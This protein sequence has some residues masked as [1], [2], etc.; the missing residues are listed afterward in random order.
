MA[1]SLGFEGRLELGRDPGTLRL[2]GLRVLA[3]ALLLDP[4]EFEDLPLERGSH[5]IGGLK[6]LGGLSDQL[7]EPFSI[8]VV[9]LPRLVQ[10]PA[11]L[12]DLRA[13]RLA[14]LA[15]I[16]LAAAQ[17]VAKC[18]TPLSDSRLDAT[19]RSSSPCFVESSSSL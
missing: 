15:K 17:L 18:A 14:F 3:L 12:A 11:K 8:L 6:S 19:S 1:R 16:L 13:L 7:L 2:E 4:D 10:R 9:G 5:G